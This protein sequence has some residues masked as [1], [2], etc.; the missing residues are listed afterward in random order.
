MTVIAS[1]CIAGT[2]IGSIFYV[3]KMKGKGFTESNSLNFPRSQLIERYF[4]FR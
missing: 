4:D 2:S 1:F 3:K